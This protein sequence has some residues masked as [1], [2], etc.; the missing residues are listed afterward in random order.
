M[1]I[2]VPNKRTTVVAGRKSES[3]CCSSFCLAHGHNRLVICVGPAAIKIASIRHGARAMVGG[4]MS[5]YRERQLTIEARGDRRL[6]A[7]RWVSWFGLVGIA[8]RV[9]PLNRSLTPFESESIPL[10]SLDPK[11]GNAGQRAD[12]TIAA[13]D[14]GH[15][16]CWWVGRQSEK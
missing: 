11:I 8:E 4:M 1:F 13:I 6:A 12:G 10:T 5:N 3:N 7:M 14:Y 15:E 16:G 2:R 9:E